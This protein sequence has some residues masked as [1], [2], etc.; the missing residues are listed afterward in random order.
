VGGVDRTLLMLN[1]LGMNDRAMQLEMQHSNFEEMFI[2]ILNKD[3][4]NAVAD[5]INKKADL[6]EGLNLSKS[7][8]EAKMRDEYIEKLDNFIYYINEHMDEIM[9]K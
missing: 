4:L 8:K 7:P 2:P 3:T 5:Y 6:V 1:H 9:A